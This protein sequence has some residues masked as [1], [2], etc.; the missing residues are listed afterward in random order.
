MGGIGAELRLGTLIGYFAGASFRG[1]AAWGLGAPGG[2][3]LY[4][5]Y[6]SAW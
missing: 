6:G 2:W 5:L 3:D 4:L 1:G